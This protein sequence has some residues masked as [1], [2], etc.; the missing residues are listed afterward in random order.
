MKE[1]VGVFDNLDIELLSHKNLFHYIGWR[2]LQRGLKLRK[3]WKKK[4][5]KKKK[6]EKIL[7]ASRSHSYA[8]WKELLCTVCVCKKWG[9]RFL[10]HLAVLTL[11][12]GTCLIV[13]SLQ[14]DWIR[15]FWTFIDSKKWICA[16]FARAFFCKKIKG[17]GQAQSAC[18]PYNEFIFHE[19]KNYF[20]IFFNL[21][22][23]GLNVV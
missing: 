5:K 15:I 14:K 18:P 2:V 16:F 22:K 23:A 8:H 7:N 21:E 9:W 19:N 17:P 12:I 4:K 6:L 10:K 11:W 1:I 20:C 3:M 13:F